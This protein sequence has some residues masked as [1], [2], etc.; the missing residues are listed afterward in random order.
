MGNQALKTHYPP[1]E[2]R[3]R[4]GRPNWRHGGKQLLSTLLTTALLGSAM[5]VGGLISTAVPAQA[6]PAVPMN[7]P[8]VLAA[9]LPGPT[10]TCQSDPNIF[11][12]GYNA[13]TGGILADNVKDPNWEVAGPF[14]IPS[15]PTSVSLPPASASWSQ[16]NVG[17]L[18]APWADSPYGNA[19]WVS[20][21][22]I[23]APVSPSGDWYYRYNFTLDPSVDPAIFSLGMDFMAD[24]NVAEVFVNGVAQSSKT[25]GLPQAPAAADGYQYLGYV[26]ANASSTTLSNDWQTGANTIIVQIKSNLPMEGF[27]AQIRPTPLCPAPSY[28]V[29]KTV[30][31]TTA[32]PGDKITYSVAIKNTGN[33]AYTAANPASFTDDLTKVLDDASYNNDA[34]NGATFTSPKL[35]W[36]GPLA[37]DQTVTI[38]YSVTVGS[39]DTGDKSLVNSVTP[40]TGGTCDP[41]GTCT[42]TSDVG[43]FSVVKK[44]T[45]NSV[46]AGATVPYTITV[47]NTGK[48]DYT[49][50]RPASFTDDLTNV[51]DDASYNGDATQ[52]ASYSAP[53]LSW[54]GPLAVGESKTITYSVKVNDP[55]SGDKKLTNTVLT[56][57]NSGGDC[58]TGSTNASCIS[59]IPGKA[60]TVEKQVSSKSAL[61]GDKITYT[62]TVKNTGQV[63]FTT[64]SPAA[65]ADDLSKVLDDASYNND[66]SNGATISGSTLSWSG[67]LAI[68]ASQSIT[69]SVTVNKPDSG[70][71]IL[72]NSVIPTV[73]GGSCAT[74]TGCA[75]TTGVQ[76]YTVAKSSKPTGNV[77]PGNKI[78][79][80][81]TIKNPGTIDYTNAAPAGFTDDLSKVL[82]D[83]TYNNDATNGATLSG[84]T[85]SWSG[86]LA[87]GAT[88][89]VTY[90]VTVNTPDTGDHILSNAAVPSQPGGVCA[91]KCAPVINIVAGY[92]VAKKASTGQVL[93]GQKVTYTVTVTNTGAMDYTAANPASFADDL[94]KVLDDASY[95]NDA[96]NGATFTAPKLSWSGALAVGKTVTV[97]YSVTVN[98]PPTGDG[99]LTNVLVP[100]GAAG[101]CD[102]AATCQTDT[103][104]Q[105]FSVVK[106]ASV[107]QS[108]PGGVVSYT[109]TVKNTGAVAYTSQN[110]ASFVDNLANVLD[111]ASYNGDASGGA[112]Y[113]APMLSWSGALGVGQTHTITYSVTVGNPGTGDKHLRNSVVTPLDG[114][115]PVGSKNPNC[116]TDTP[117]AEYKIT[118]TADATSVVP[119]DKITYTIS[120]TNTG[121]VPYTGANQATFTDD[122]AKVLDDATYN[123]DASSG[124]TYTAPVISWTGDLAVG[125]TVKIT[126]S[127][128]VNTPDTGDKVLNNTVV[129]TTPGGNCPAGTTNSQCSAN[130]PGPQLV[131]SKTASAATASP[132]EK[133]TYTITLKNEGAGDFTSAK[134]ASFTDN[135]SAVLD[136]ATYNDDATAGMSYAA[137][138]LSWS[139]A[140][141]SGE[142]KTLT[143][144]VTINNPDTGDRKL[145]NAVFTPPNV[146]SNCQPESTDPKCSATTRVG[147]YSVTKSVSSKTAKPGDTLT[148]SVTVTNTGQLA[149]TKEK[150][151]GFTDDLTKV[152]D[153][154]TYNNDAS[155]GA[156]FKNKT[157]SW[158]GPLAI[159]ATTTITYT[160][161]VKNPATGDRELNNAAIP[162]HPG[163]SCTVAQCPPVKSLISSF[164]VAKSVSTATA[165]VGEKVTYTVTVTNTGQVDYTKENPAQFTDDMSKVL[166]QSSYNNDAS[167][168]AVLKGKTLSWAGPVAVGKTAVVTYSVTVNKNSGDNKLVNLVIVPPSSGGICQAG[169]PAPSCTRTTTITPPAAVP[170]APA[171][172]VAAPPAGNN[173]A[174]TGSPLD[175]WVIAAAFG[176]IFTGASL[177]LIRRHRSRRP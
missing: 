40:G 7:V 93:P 110:P 54:S 60:F 109:V 95:N 9:A 111:D 176:L 164:D 71:G 12:T 39:P 87:A 34:S 148:Y 79:Y 107:A 97:T 152:L 44:S 113:S 142:S 14:A 168:G 151:A 27:D 154:A 134:P 69:Y 171:P 36:S 5:V 86:P 58:P 115:C 96:S 25:T 55:L 119:G 26:T 163:G 145:Q 49:T 114:G 83:A 56:P 98:N 84:S 82:D 42:T 37:V 35:S 156:V 128:T 150:P 162:N 38:T 125:A 124:A 174:Y 78:T 66:A 144:S 117:V 13:A 94:T 85:L 172:P 1:K 99:K 157:L 61:P 133:I 160:V 112:S 32:L 149:Y 73:P 140:L 116:A 18:V 15:L 108:I 118:K 43:S 88:V 169:S 57:P 6:G 101:T 138:V 70:D 53:N 139:G 127:V 46:I 8:G 173:L 130:I 31:S 166:S 161:T 90:S 74:P 16:A 52:G 81:V 106:K 75:T 147:T 159:G 131:I 51:L 170:P 47:T 137:P 146:P 67:A 30:S 136:D 21:Q 72:T 177:T 91:T 28:T 63:D 135:L 23:A 104:I 120:V 50:A 41:A 89:T 45:A 33:T 123:N 29:A 19:Q 143:Y 158:N 141:A 80:T 3:P 129:S 132:G 167:N 100:T 103:P 76:S 105:S 2:I 175:W 65:F 165:S 155:N 122:L 102:T 68:G 77:V 11:N 121:A 59:E 48:V 24:N 22:T 64:T 17:K 4:L 92:T 20:Q 62:V 153:D 10:V 126:Y